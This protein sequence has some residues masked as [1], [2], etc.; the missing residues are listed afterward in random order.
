VK[1]RTRQM[2]TAL[3]HVVVSG[4]GLTENSYGVPSPVMRR[5]N[6]L[7]RGLIEVVSAVVAQVQGVRGP[8]EIEVEENIT[9]QNA[10]L[11]E[12]GSDL[13]MLTCIFNIVFLF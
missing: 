2:D 6:P 5:S 13:H 1:N 12:P 4:M 10:R 7:R 3:C 9:C 8:Q 11:F